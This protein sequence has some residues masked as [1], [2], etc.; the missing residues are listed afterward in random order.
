MRSI[1]SAAVIALSGAVVAAVPAQAAF[2]NPATNIFTGNF[3]NGVISDLGALNLR[4]GP[5]SVNGAIAGTNVGAGVTFDVFADPLLLGSTG[6]V[7]LLLNISGSGF[8]I[9][10][11]SYDGVDLVFATTSAGMEALFAS[12]FADTS[13]FDTF[14]LEFANGATPDNVQISITSV[15]PLPASVFMLLAALGGLGWVSRRRRMPA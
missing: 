2:I 8:N 9:V 4:D 1:L 10:N 11:A 13:D 15:I 14:F 3:D 5:I 12:S 7:Q 6:A